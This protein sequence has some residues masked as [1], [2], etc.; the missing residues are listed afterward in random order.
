M[1]STKLHTTGSELTNVEDPVPCRHLQSKTILISEVARQINCKLGVNEQYEGDDDL[2]QQKTSSKHCGLSHETPNGWS[3]SDSD[4]IDRLDNRRIR[5]V[6]ELVQEKFSSVSLVHGTNHWRIIM[7]VLN[8]DESTAWSFINPDLSET[9][10][11]EFFWSSF[12]ISWIRVILYQ[13]S[14]SVN[15]SGGLTRER[16]SF[17][18]RDVHP[19]QYG[20]ICPIAT[21]EGPNIGL[22]LHFASFSRVDQWF[23]PDSI[24]ERFLHFVPNDGKSAINRI[25]L[26]DVLDA[27]GKVVVPE[28][29]LMTATHAKLLQTNIKDKEILVR[30]YLTDDYEYVDAYIERNF[31]IAGSQLTNW[32][33]W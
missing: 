22:V 23:Y 6:G 17:E 20:R 8:L 13:S 1:H 19:T 25:T 3:N 4:D 33:I 26:E 30:G 32:W 31:T 27:K 29:T 11:K 14:H 7:T 18:V 9:V 5:S 21:P 2:Y 24:T 16:A 10:V 28:K 12:W 15:G